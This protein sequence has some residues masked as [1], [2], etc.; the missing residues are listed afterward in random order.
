MRRANRGLTLT[1]LLT[2]V[3]VIVI[4]TSIAAPMFVYVR[5]LST[6]A[7]CVKN[8]Q[9]IGVTLAAMATLPKC[10]E[11]ESSGA[12]KED[13]W[14]YNKVSRALFPPPL[15]DPFTLSADAFRAEQ[16]VLRCPG[17]RDNYNQ[18]W[19]PKNVSCA[20]GGTSY[21]IHQLNPSR[22]DKDRC[23]DD[24]YGYNNVG[25]VYDPA[26]WPSG[27]CLPNPD[28]AT[29]VPLKAYPVSALY[30]S[31]ISVKGVYDTGV[32]SATGVSYGYI[33]GPGEFLEAGRTILLMD[34]VKA[35]A[36]PAPST[37]V[38]ANGTTWV[39]AV[40]RL[41]GYS[42]RHGG[43]ANVMFADFH[44]Q[45]YSKNALLAAVGSQDT[46]TKRARIHWEVI[47]P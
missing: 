36:Q 1:E 39:T 19:A 40:D 15:K 43:A 20:I 7:K 21:N 32:V 42:F 11:V 24:S 4:F 44:V 29:E 27:R 13:Q 12:V 45:T 3:A 23:Y 35:D 8:M 30:H 31:G 46:I 22:D 17:S 34:Y 26:G 6:G 47:K 33:G 2:V 25:F 10:V 5:H 28:S 37:F 9:Q 41:Y 14:W 18:A 38:R 16:F